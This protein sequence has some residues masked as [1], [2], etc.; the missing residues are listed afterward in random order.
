MTD[1]S[2]PRIRSSEFEV[3]EV[4]DGAG[5]SNCPVPSRTLRTALTNLDTEN[6]DHGKDG[7]T[8]I[9]V[10]RRLAVLG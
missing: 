10:K 8:L 5:V 1:D 7:V 4:G 9:V 6:T 3:V 2:G